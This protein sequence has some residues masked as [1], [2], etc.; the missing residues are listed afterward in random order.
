MCFSVLRRKPHLATMTGCSGDRAE[1]QSE[2]GCFCDYPGATR[3]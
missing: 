1:A 2:V 3:R